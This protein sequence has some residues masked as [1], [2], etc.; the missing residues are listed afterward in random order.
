MNLRNKLCT[1]GSGLK[2]K[3]CCG[4]EAVKAAKC[5]EA[6]KPKPPDPPPQSNTA[7]DDERQMMNRVV[8]PRNRP[9]KL[10]ALGLAMIAASMMAS[11]GNFEKIPDKLRRK[12]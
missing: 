6:W 11:S 4:N 5:Q 10:G 9:G 3:K 7:S 2:N 8:R 12:F 1:C